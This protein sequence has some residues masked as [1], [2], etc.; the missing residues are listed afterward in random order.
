M[1]LV[2]LL[3]FT[4]LQCGCLVGRYREVATNREVAYIEEKGGDLPDSTRTGGTTRW[5]MPVRWPLPSWPRS[6]PR[7][8]LPADGG[9]DTGPVSL[10]SRAPRPEARAGARP[11]FAVIPPASRPHL[12]LHAGRAATSCQAVAPTV[13]DRAGP[14]LRL[15]RRRCRKRPERIGLPVH[16]VVPAPVTR[17]AGDLDLEAA[18]G[19]RR[20][21]IVR[22]VAEHV[23]VARLGV[24]PLQRL[25]E[26]VLLTTAMPPV[27]SASTRRLSCDFLNVVAPT[28]SDRPARR[29]PATPTSPR[30]S[31]V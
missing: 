9:A 31:I 28:R 29:C 1:S 2:R 12:R 7:R 18:V 26:V 22:V 17:L 3:G 8:I 15:R 16:H 23:V 14:R 11:C 25:V 30:G 27:C 20:V 5:P 19:T 10:D 6:A 21:G 24:D 4:T 13:A